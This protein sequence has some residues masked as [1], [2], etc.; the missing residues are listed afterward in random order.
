MVESIVRRGQDTHANS[1]FP[2]A[3]NGDQKYPLL[4]TGTSRIFLYM[5]VAGIRGRTML[6]AVLSGVA[7]GAWP[8]QTL[9]VAPITEKWS[10]GWL[11]WSN[12]PAVGTPTATASLPALADGERFQVDIT[13]L[14]QA[15]ANGA[16][17]HGWRIVTSATGP[18]RVYGFDSGED[19]WTLTYEFSDAPRA[20]T[21]LSPDGGVIAM[22]KPT[23][24]CDFTDLGGSS[25]EQV[26]IQVQVDSN[27]D[28]TADWDSGEVATAVPELNLAGTS[29]P[30][31]ASGAAT[32]WRVRVKD[33]AGLWSDYSNWATFTYVAKPAVTVT[34]PASGLIFDPTPTI[35]A[36][37]P[38]GYSLKAWRIRITAGSD[39]SKV[40]YDSGKRNATDPTQIQHTLPVKNDNGRRILVDDSTYWLNVRVWDRLDREATP[41]DPGYTETW[42]Q[43]TF[44]D[45][46]TASAPTAIWANQIGDTPRVRLTWE[47]PDTPE[48]WVILRDGNVV[49]R[50]DTDEVDWSGSAYSWI[51]SEAA[52]YTSHEWTVKAMFN[53]KQSPPS[54]VASV[55]TE[56]MGTWLLT[57]AGD[58][59]V[60]DGRE[61]D[62]WAATDRRATYKPMGRSFDVDIITAFE[63]VAGQFDGTIQDRGG[64]DLD[65]AI[66]TL[67]AIKDAP[68]ETVRL[69]SASLNIPVLLRNVSVTPA[70]EFQAHNRRQ[71]V[72]FG[73]WQ[74]A[75]FDSEV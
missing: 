22:P 32:K 73:F 3:E 26:S 6:S 18:E 39:K 56:T 1:A 47:Y 14:V 53:A 40:R 13:P 7:R 43:F 75:D 10:S 24:T 8:A 52:P 68:G 38:G 55:R 74:V 4:A 25:T 60:L 62:S 35:F 51:D 46:A 19:S 67:R 28:G 63:G 41:G 44:D 12:Q 54:P 9:T 61:L 29:Y 57:E 31:A 36:N 34:N 49:A 42:V 15:A 71:N 70:S 2:N 20:P 45:D 50:L 64:F 30:G 69:V 16:A 66:A 37:V 58:T 65:A 72:R 59:V 17:H 23:V 33:G 21:T 48:G 11:N 5:P 27:G